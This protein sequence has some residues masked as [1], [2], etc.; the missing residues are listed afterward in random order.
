MIVIVYH[1][2]INTWNPKLGFTGVEFLEPSLIIAG[3]HPFIMKAINS[4]DL[5]IDHV[6]FFSFFCHEYKS[7][8]NAFERIQINHTSSMLQRNLRK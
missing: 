4:R 2:D 6:S 5:I 1:A 7:S 3:V 8:K